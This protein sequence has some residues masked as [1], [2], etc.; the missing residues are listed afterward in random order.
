MSELTI[1]K[2][3]EAANAMACEALT[4]LAGRPNVMARHLR[5]WMEDNAADTDTTRPEL[6]EAVLHYLGFAFGKTFGS[7]KQRE[8]LEL[9]QDRDRG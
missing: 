4:E 3:Q 8:R 2:V 5:D 6:Q 1:L 7:D 9:A